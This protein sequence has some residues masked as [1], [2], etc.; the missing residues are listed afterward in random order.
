MRRAMRAARGQGRRPRRPRRSARDSP[1][2]SLHDDCRADP[3]DLGTVVDRN[4][5]RVLDEAERLRL[6]ERPLAEGGVGAEGAAQ[7]L[8]RGATADSFVLCLEDGAQAAMSQLP[9]EAVIADRG[10]CQA[11]LGGTRIRRAKPHGRYFRDRRPVIQGIPLPPSRRQ[12]PASQGPGLSA[13]LEARISYHVGLISPPGGRGPMQTPATPEEC[14]S[15]I[16]AV[17]PVRERKL[18]DVPYVELFGGRLQGVVSSGS[19]PNRVYVSFFTAGDT[20]FNCSTNNNRP[21]GGLRG[22]PCKHLIQLL[23]EGALQYGVERVI[24]YLQLPCDPGQAKSGRDLIRHIKG[25]Q[26]K[27][28][29]SMVFSRFL[30]YLRHVE[31]PG[32]SEPAPEMAWFVAG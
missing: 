8:D 12:G 1:R 31:L 17:A 13:G 32:S 20:N 19:D 23:N 29:V 3:V 4:D 15:V 11:Q 10:P 14:T 24:R 26:T 28:D 6:G 22:S 5:A 30:N 27:A 7:D 16:R 18:D 21:C 9:E 25:T 2:R